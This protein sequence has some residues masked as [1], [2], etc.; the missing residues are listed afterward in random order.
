MNDET[1]TGEARSAAT[2]QSA[3]R[4]KKVAV[5]VIHGMGEQRPMDTLRGFVQAVWLNDPE[6]VD[7]RTNQIY[8]KPDKITGNFELRRITTRHP[9]GGGHRVDFFEFYWAHLMTGNTIGRDRKSVV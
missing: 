7:V 5:V 8:S 4:Q 2:A 3:E 1:E 6:L 9:K